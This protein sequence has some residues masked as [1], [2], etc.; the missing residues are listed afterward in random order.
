MSTSLIPKFLHSSFNKTKVVQVGIL[1]NISLKKKMIKK[2]H[3]K[4]KF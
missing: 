3:D 4:D 2:T 1:G